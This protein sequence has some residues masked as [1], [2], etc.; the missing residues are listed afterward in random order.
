MSLAGIQIF[1]PSRTIDTSFDRASAAPFES[2]PGAIPIAIAYALYI[3]IMY[4]MYSTV[5]IR[6]A[7]HLRIAISGDARLT[8]D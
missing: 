6:L 8:R 3:N 2:Q 5:R 7:T 4:V 1:A